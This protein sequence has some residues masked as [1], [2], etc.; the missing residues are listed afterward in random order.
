MKNADT[1]R[2]GVKLKSRSEFAALLTNSSPRRRTRKSIFFGN[3]NTLIIRH[4]YYVPFDLPF[5]VCLRHSLG[6]GILKTCQHI[7]DP[8]I[9]DIGRVGEAGCRWGAQLSTALFAPFWLTLNRYYCAPIDS[10]GC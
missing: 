6:C 7:S 9:A 8:L 4:P 1:V 10:W 3:H 2:S 5:A